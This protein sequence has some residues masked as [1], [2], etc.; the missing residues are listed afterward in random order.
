MEETQTGT[1][2]CSQTKGMNARLQKSIVLKCCDYQ[3]WLVLSSDTSLVGAV[4]F[5][6]HSK[7]KKSCRLTD[8]HFSWL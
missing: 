1:A 2:D 4:N 6:N 3:V 8:F 5:P 7:E